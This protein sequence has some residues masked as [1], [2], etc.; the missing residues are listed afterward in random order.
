MSVGTDDSQAIHNIVNDVLQ[1]LYFLNP[2]ELK[3]IVGIDETIQHLELSLKSVRAIGIWGM[4]GKGLFAKLFPQY[5]SVCF[6]PNISEESKRIGLTS[7]RNKLFS[8]LLKEEI[9]LFDVVG[10]TVIMRRLGSKRVLLV[11]DDVDS[12]EQLECLCGER[13]D[14]GEDITLIVTTRDKHLLSG[15]VDEIYE[16]NQRS[17][18]ESR[19]L[20]CLHAFKTRHPQEGYEGLSNRAIHYAKGIPLALKVLGSH[21]Y[22]RNREFW[23][24]TLRKL[25]KYPNEKIL[26]VLKV[27]YDGLDSLEKKIFLDIAFFFKDKDKHQAVWI[28]D[29]CGFFAVSG[30]DILIDKSLVTISHNNTIQM[31]DLLQE[32]GWDIVRKECWGNPGRR[33][34]LRANEAYDVLNNNKGTDVVEVITLDLSQIVDLQLSA[35]TFNRM[36]NLRFLQLYVPGGKRSG[37]LY[38]CRVLEAFSDELRYFEWDGFPL[39]SLPPNFCAQHLVVIRMPHSHVKELWQGVQDLVNL[40]AIDLRECKQLV[41]LPDLSRA[42]KL[43]LVNL[44][45]CESLSDVDPSVLSLEALESLILDNCIKLKS[46]TRS[47]V[48][49]HLAHRTK[50]SSITIELPSQRADLLGLVYSVVLNPPPTMEQGAKIHCQCRLVDGTKVGNEITWHQEAIWGLDSDHV[51]IW[52][53]SFHSDRILHYY[54]RLRFEFFVTTKNGELISIQECGVHLMRVSRSEFYKFLRETR[55]NVDLKLKFGLMLDTKV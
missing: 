20:F 41:K 25:D 6:M 14:L 33:S 24:S 13:G 7:L 53:D 28:L 2:N 30:L 19:E 36:P 3:G 21:L 27:S 43:V 15:R 18:E 45:G 5:D 38:H 52:Y 29:A 17:F 55:M 22:S 9:P 37:T 34:R 44:Y 40:E 46:L 11:L 51:F 50:E 23:K 32:M 31:H 42:S 8:E 47:R 54:N 39:S 26:N 35:D 1:K 48:P 10:S 12:F 49:T 16:V 4:G